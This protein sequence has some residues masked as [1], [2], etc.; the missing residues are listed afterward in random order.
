[1]YSNFFIYFIAAFIL[2]YFTARETSKHYYARWNLMVDSDTIR[3]DKY[4]V[5]SMC[6]R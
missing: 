4:N 5:V 2:F 6:Y 1:M 3:Y